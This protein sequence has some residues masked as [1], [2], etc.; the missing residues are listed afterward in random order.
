MYFQD[1]ARFGRM[2]DPVRCWAP[3]GSR[4]SVRVQRIRE[5]THVYSAVCLA[6]GD[7]FSLILPYVNT[8]MMS[9]FLKEFS[10]PHKT[11]VW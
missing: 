4:P 11:I 1:E 9:L 2:H 7:S 8:E 10:R 6:D 5:Y 3:E